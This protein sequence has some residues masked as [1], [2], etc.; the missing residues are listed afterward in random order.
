M[1]VRILGEGQFELPAD[2]LDAL[3][4]LD[5]DLE[6][7]LDGDAGA[8]AAALAALLD[9]VREVGTPLADEALEPSEI[10]LPYAEATPDEVRE[11]L[12]DDGLIP[13]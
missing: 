8:F 13:G 9:K 4:R 7:S 10:V 1:I 2:Q 5:A 6:G 12:G 11:L 3:N